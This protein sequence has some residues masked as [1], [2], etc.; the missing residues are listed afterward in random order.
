MAKSYL[1]SRSPTFYAREGDKLLEV[2]LTFL[3]DFR[4]ESREDFSFGYVNGV[5]CENCYCSPSAVAARIWPGSA[6]YSSR[7]A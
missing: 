6:I 2:D 5:F 4:L 1:R 3:I 7:A